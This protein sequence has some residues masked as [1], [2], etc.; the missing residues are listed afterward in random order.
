MFSTIP[1]TFTTLGWNS[2]ILKQIS[3]H[4]KWNTCA[5]WCNIGL[6]K[7]LCFCLVLT[8]NQYDDRRYL[9]KLEPPHISYMCTIRMN[10]V[11]IQ[12]LYKYKC[13]IYSKAS[14]FESITWKFFLII[15][16]RYSHHLVISASQNKCLIFP[17]SFL[18]FTIPSHLNMT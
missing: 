18:N 17:Y 1:S 6:V 4:H 11:N 14:K 13:K 2:S 3:H 7:F 9:I 10:V 5:T 12:F 16:K 15:M 8:L